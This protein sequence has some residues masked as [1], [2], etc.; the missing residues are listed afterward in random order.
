MLNKY[1]N[2][3]FLPKHNERN[4]LGVAMKTFQELFIK[5]GKAFIDY[6]SSRPKS[7]NW[8]RNIEYEKRLEDT[9]PSQICFLYSGTALPPA[10]I[11]IA[12][13]DEDQ[14][15]VSNIVPEG[16]TSL[17]VIGYNELLNSWKSEYLS[18]F[19]HEISTTASEITIE[20]TTNAVIAEAFN[21]FSRTANKSTGHSHPLDEEKW[22][23]II[24]ECVMADKYIKHE[25]LQA[26]LL[27]DGWEEDTAYEL[28]ID[29]EYGVAAMKYY[30]DR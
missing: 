17:S 26:E 13:N 29:Y 14:Q 2:N 23:R 30:K 25:L 20:S 9:G 6:V 1:S 11:W 3:S 24:F 27:D 10:S 22:F 16:A 21:A 19:V 5:N 4:Q 15:Y 28:V 18:E 12:E 8:E 7:G